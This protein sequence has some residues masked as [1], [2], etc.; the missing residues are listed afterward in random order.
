MI[1]SGVQWN[2]IFTPNNPDD[3]L[4][5]G[6]VMVMLAVDALL[7]LFIALYVEAVFPGEYGV[8]QPWYYLFT[9]SYWC[10]PSKTS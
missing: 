7:Y 2:N 10:G 5:L 8:P 9:S 4:S 3:G 6:L 1:V